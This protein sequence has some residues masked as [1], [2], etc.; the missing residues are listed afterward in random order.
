MRF[1]TLTGAVLTAAA[2]ALG[3][4][5]P[6]D[7]VRAA[8]LYDTGLVHE[9]IMQKKMAHWKA[10]EEAGLMDSSKWPRL[11][12]TKCVDGVAAAVPGDPLLTFRCKNVR[13]LQSAQYRS[14]I[15]FN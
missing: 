10:E 7:E 6:V 3:R 12:Y 4:E 15:L 8:E 13:L 11:N 5:L 2:P 1:S 9:T 14:R